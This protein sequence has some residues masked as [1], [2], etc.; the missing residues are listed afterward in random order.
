M[1]VATPTLPVVV[2]GGAVGLRAVSLQALAGTEHPLLSKRMPERTPLLRGRQGR[3]ER[4]VEAQAW[5]GDFPNQLPIAKRIHTTARKHSL[6]TRGGTINTL[7]PAR[8]ELN[9]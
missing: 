4:A 8:D 1:T 6:S 9:F 3:R 5:A 7:V 2:T